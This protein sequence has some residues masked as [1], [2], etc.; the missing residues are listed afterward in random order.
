MYRRLRGA[1]GVIREDVRASVRDVV[2]HKP[3][4]L[5]QREIFHTYASR[6]PFH[7]DRSTKSPIWSRFCGCCAAM[8]SD[9]ASVIRSH[10]QQRIKARHEL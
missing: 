9:T 7:C 4:Y 1:T 3:R 5:L 6:V 2:V 8:T 10:I